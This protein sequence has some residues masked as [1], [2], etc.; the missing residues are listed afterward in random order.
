AAAAFDTAYR[1]AAAGSGGDGDAALLRLF[2]IDEAALQV[3]R[4]APGT[5]RERATAIHALA[6]LAARLKL[7]AAAP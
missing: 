1:R 2:G 3:V 4:S 6:S 5:P 7:V